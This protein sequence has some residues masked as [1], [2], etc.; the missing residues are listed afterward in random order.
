MGRQGEAGTAHASEMNCSPSGLSHLPCLVVTEG[1]QGGVVPGRSRFPG[2]A[3]GLLHNAAAVG[4]SGCLGALVPY[5]DTSV[6]SGLVSCL[7]TSATLAYNT[8]T[9]TLPARGRRR[10][11]SADRSR[12]RVELGSTVIR[13]W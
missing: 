13:R 6:A 9:G 7:D 5:C 4:M 3:L 8:F 1:T 10:Q 11:W 2:L 12:L